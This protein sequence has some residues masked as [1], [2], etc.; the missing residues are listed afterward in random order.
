M[1]YFST[2]DR[3]LALDSAG[4]VG[5]AILRRNDFGDEAFYSG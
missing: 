2:A 1:R 5:D 4:S 3:E